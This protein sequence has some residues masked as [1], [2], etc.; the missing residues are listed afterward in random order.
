MKS[1]PVGMYVTGR[2]AL[3]RLDA[4]VKFLAFLLLIAAV[5]CTDTLA[6]YG[7]L[8]AACVLCAA[9]SGMKAEAVLASVRRLVP[10]FVLIFFM[11]ACFS[12]EG[13]AWV[14]WWIFCPSPEGVMKGVNMVA[15]VLLALVLSNLLALTTPP[16][17]LTAA[18]EWLMRPLA[19]V[20]VPT[21]QIAM[22]LSVAIGF[23]PTLFEQTDAIRKAQTA[24]GARFDSR[25]LVER[26]RAILPLVVPVF[27][28]AFKR[29]DELALAMEARG[30]RGG[31]RKRRFAPVKGSALWALCFAAAVLAAEIW[32]F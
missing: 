27:L 20:R 6:D 16:M 10:F 9:L 19:L 21:G 30:Y 11:N 28:A 24:R 2:S 17:D 32:L 15:R 4:R 12:G 14:R 18:M 22:I 7:V 31:G 13:T 29:A 3:H 1:L 5:C 26:G 25:R 8:T 23:V